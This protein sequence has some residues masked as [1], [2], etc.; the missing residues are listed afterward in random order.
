MVLG[1]VLGAWALQQQAT[2]PQALPLILVWCALLACCAWYMR[3]RWPWTDQSPRLFNAVRQSYWFIVAVLLGFTWASA[4]A[5]YRLSDALPHAWEQKTITLVGVVASLPEYTEHGQRF[6]FDVEQVLT[7][8]AQVPKRISLSIYPPYPSSQATPQSTHS[9]PQVKVGERW[10][11]S[12]RLKRPHG[13]M[14]PQGFDFEAWA[15]SERIRATGAVRLKSDWRRLS[16]SVNHP[17]YWVDAVRAKVGLRIAQ[18][19]ADKPYAG[20][21]RALVIGDDS[22]ISRAD[23]DTY[24]RTGTIHLMSISYLLKH[25]FRY[26]L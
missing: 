14:N 10:Q 24:M 19:L 13:V 25:I 8:Q 15:L 5:T 22:Q 7:P 1:V 20:V 17:R 9:I 3:Q 2:L 11:W 26:Y 18:V 23:W 12:V 21:I 16:A 6:L 4:L